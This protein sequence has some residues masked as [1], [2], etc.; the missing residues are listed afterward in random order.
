VYFDET[1]D[2]NS[3]GF[4]ALA[5]PVAGYRDCLQRLR[6]FRKALRISDGI[7][8]TTEFHAAKFTSGR[9][10]L[11]KKGKGLSQRRRCEI[12]QE[13]LAFI[14]GLPDVHLLNA[15]RN[16]LPRDKPLLLERLLNRVHTSVQSWGSQA[17]LLFDEGDARNITK[18]VRKLIVYNPIKSKFGTWGDGKEFKNFPLSGFLEDPVFRISR[19]SYMIQ[20]V[21]FCAYALFQKE[22]PT[23]SR[24]VMS[25]NTALERHLAPICVR[26]AS[27][28][29][30]GIVR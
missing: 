27:Q 5:I 14:A 22:K 10:R 29:P 19:N 2:E 26:E 16:C 15:F 25:L 21:D 3:V 12:F 9:G 8:T 11:G 1:G 28:D 18:L 20:A 4:S 30:F 24:T 17:V 23:P 13:T 7:Y 6:D